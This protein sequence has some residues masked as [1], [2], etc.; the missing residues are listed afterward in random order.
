MGI[1]GNWRVAKYLGE[2]TQE[3][4][5]LFSLFFSTVATVPPFSQ[6]TWNAVRAS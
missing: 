5:V 3:W 2:G 1:K 4:Y 6:V